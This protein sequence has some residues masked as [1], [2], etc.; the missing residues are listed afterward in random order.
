MSYYVIDQTTNELL[1]VSDFEVPNNFVAEGHHVHESPIS[2][3]ELL[4]RYDWSSAQN[5]FILKDT[6]LTK[7]NFIKKFTVQE[8]ANIKTAA[9]QNAVLDY[10]WQLFMLAEYVDLADPDTISGIHMLEQVGLLQQG[11]AEEILNG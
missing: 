1:Y 11:R 10:Y 3:Q 2:A 6:K 5:T 4:S 8:Y 7:R 9:G